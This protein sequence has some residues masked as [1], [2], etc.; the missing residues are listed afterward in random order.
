ME[1]TCYVYNNYNWSTLIKACIAMLKGV[2]NYS[3]FVIGLMI[4]AQE[5]GPP[6]PGLYWQGLMLIISEYGLV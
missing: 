1:F 5:L 2:S 4:D 6:P 3:V